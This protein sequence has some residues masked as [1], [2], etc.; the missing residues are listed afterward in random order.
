[1][2]TS[3]WIRPVMRWAALGLSSAFLVAC[4]TTDSAYELVRQQQE[5]E[6]FLQS[7]EIEHWEKRKPSDRQMAVRMLEET[8]KQGRYFASLAYAEA[9]EKEYGA[10]PEVMVLRAE[11]QR[12]TGQLEQAAHTFQSLVNTPVAGRA[13]QGL[14]LIAGS[15]QHFEQAAHYLKQAAQQDPTNAI[16]QSDLA[17]A[18]LRSGRPQEARLAL[19]KAAELAPDNPKILSNMALYLLVSQEPQRA[20]FVMQQAGM[21]SATQQAVAQMA[22]QI[23]HELEQLHARQQQQKQQDLRLAAAAQDEQ[24]RAQVVALSPA[25]VN[26]VTQVGASRSVHSR[27]PVVNPDGGRAVVSATQ[28]GLNRPLLESL[29]PVPSSMN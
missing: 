18:Y 10:D 16:V 14:G 26:T 1:M 13:Y 28:A 2:K 7:K 23:G 4:S 29:G 11:A 6:A 15:Q 5:Q 25:T 27:N 24:A 19:G 8:Q 3:T 9:M 22:E 12:Q 21:D 17:Y 20:S